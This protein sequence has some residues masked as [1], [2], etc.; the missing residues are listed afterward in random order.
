M[1]RGAGTTCW[2]K[3]M[4]WPWSFLSDDPQHWPKQSSA[5][6]RTINSAWGEKCAPFDACVSTNTLLLTHFY[7][8]ILSA[9]PQ[10]KAHRDLLTGSSLPA[11][12]VQHGSFS[13]QDSNRCMLDLLTESLFYPLLT[14]FTSLPSLLCIHTSIPFL[15][16]FPALWPYPLQQLLTLL[17]SK[18]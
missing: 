10:A 1:M 7:K 15:F 6:K 3:V 8:Q 17:P 13:R 14:N 18:F 9:L 2:I 16:P 4:A 5:G 11:S 12:A